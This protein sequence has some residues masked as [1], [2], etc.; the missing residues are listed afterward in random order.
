MNVYD[1]LKNLFDEGLYS[2]IIQLLSLVQ[3]QSHNYFNQLT[4][5]QEYQ[6]YIYLGDAYFHEGDFVKAE[7]QYQL[8]L[9]LKRTALKN[10]KKG[11][12]S[13]FL[14]GASEADL[15]FKIAN[16]Y[17]NLKQP[18]DA[19]KILDSIPQKQ[20]GARVNCLLGD[21][22]MS[23]KKEHAQAYYREV[24]RECPHSLKVILN[25]IKLGVK[26][27][28]IFNLINISN[29]P[30]SEW[31]STWIKAHCYLH[32]PDVCQA[33]SH[34]RSLLGSNQFKNNA[35]LLQNLGEAF[36]YNGDYKKAISALRKAHAND[37]LSLKALDFYAACLYKEKQVKELEKLANELVPLCE[38]DC[39]A[40]EPWIVLG[41]YCLSVEKFDKKDFKDQKEQ[42]VHKA[43]NF[44]EKACNLSNN[45]I[46]A[47]ILGGL[48]ELKINTEKMSDK[49]DRSERNRDFLKDDPFK[50]ARKSFKDAL[51][52]CQ[53]RFEAL[54][55]L[56]DVYLAE[57]R[58]SQASSVVSNAFKLLGQNSRTLTLYASIL[59][60]DSEKRSN[61]KNAL[62][63]LEKAISMDPGFLPAV[64]M[65]VNLLS[66]DKNW[67]R[68]IEILKS[69]IEVESCDKLHRMLA[70]CYK[71]KG[72]H[73]KSLHHQNIASKLE[74]NHAG[75][76]QT[77]SQRLE[78]QSCRAAN[79]VSM[80]VDEE[81]DLDDD[82]NLESENEI[83]SESDP[84]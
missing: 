27:N 2:D 46:E 40:P 44:V 59:L 61:K 29:I 70:N 64:Y 79:D 51:S 35:D 21:L 12:N 11:Q 72:E 37:P 17:K 78:H 43:Q 60:L 58:K 54:K 20:R 75:I 47:L 4:P 63:S 41:Y 13:W 31:L 45:S 38:S 55:G 84:Q 81:V 53:Y 69:A 16:C 74:L 30:N 62:S 10:K 49:G 19:I 66:E 5:V 83:E 18:A 48:L 3:P 52:L 39:Q 80:E 6:I 7:K 71:E 22:Y 28:D 14:D 1:I 82:R 77:S 42:R 57:N 67:N 26:A 65:L 9:D 56:T 33:I 24:L 32:S 25:M 8:S 15:K 76:W 34:F 68:A 23:V 73:D 36:Y 50:D